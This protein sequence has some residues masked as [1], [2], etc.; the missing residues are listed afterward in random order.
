MPVGFLQKRGLRDQKYQGQPAV[1]DSYRGTNS[2][3]EAVRF[4]TALEK[5]EGADERF[6]WRT[7]S[8]VRL[9]GL[10]R[11]GDIRKA[12]YVI[13]VEGESDVQ[14]LWYHGIAA[15]GI[16]GTSN[17]KAEWADYLE[18]VEKIYAVIEPDQ[19][20]DT[21]RQKLSAS[22]LRDRLYVVDLG[23]HKDANGLYLSDRERFEENLKR[24]LA[25]AMPLSEL[26]RREAA[27]K[28]REA[29]VGCE[30]L[31]REPNILE[32][33]ARD[34]ARCGVAGESRVAKLLYLAVTSRFLDRPVSVEVK[35]P[36]SGGKSYLTERVLGF[37]PASAYYARTAM[38]ERALAYSEEPL[39]H[40]FLVLY[41][42]A[43][44]NSDFAS[45]LIRSLLSEGRLSYEVV[46]KTSEGLK[47]RVIEREGPT[48][49]LVT[50][51]AVKLHPE[52]ETRILSL[53]VTDTRQQTRDIMAALAT[54]TTGDPPDLEAYHSL[55]EWLASAE[56]RVAVPYAGE[57]AAAIPPVA[58]RLRRD[59]G[60]LLNLIRAHAILHQASRERTHDGR[61]VATLEDYA[62]V[63][64][65]VADL[66]SE[67][68]KATVPATVRETV[69]MVK[70]LREE[71]EKDVTIAA[72][73]EELE[74]DKSTT[75][76]RVRSAMDRRYL[77]NQE[78]RKG[79]PAKLVVADALPD[80]IEILPAPERLQGCT[81]ASDLGGLRQTIILRPLIRREK[82]SSSLP[83]LGR[84]QP[85][86]HERSSSFERP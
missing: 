4:R 32:R 12:C 72:L 29:W 85:C 1:R 64:E 10:W 40:R 27:E 30:E 50:T 83:P 47:P 37:F 36:S 78:D 21:L 17:W 54:E 34:L 22:G 2:A 81:V 7:G 70:R 9:Y 51:T 33:F 58:V 44:M 19:G 43:G 23:E 25:A 48:G 41:E 71:I 75:W 76:R 56:H 6:R 38:S 79:R 46:D 74:L 13:L 14:T 26:E 67:G 53:T 63:R 45:Y 69:E 52:N 5:S 68:I 8:K 66:V 39:Q 16:P 59:F 28:A 60:A 77:E 62:R 61:I 49:L 18:G 31:A 15:L 35:G 84:L 80:D 11:L 82:K 20:G 42:A 24:A 55:Q 65:L 3:E 73:A 86:N 57:L